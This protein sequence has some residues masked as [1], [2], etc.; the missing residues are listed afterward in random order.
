VIEHV[1][2]IPSEFKRRDLKNSMKEALVQM[3]RYLQ[4]KLPLGSQLLKDLSC[5]APHNI[6]DE[7]SV[8]AIG[9]LAALVPH[10]VSDREVS[11]VKDEW[12]LLRVALMGQ[13]CS[14]DHK[15]SKKKES[16]SIR[17]DHFWSKTL[18]GAGG[19][20]LHLEKVVK[21]LMCLQNGNASVER[22]LSDN[23]NTITAERTNLDLQTLKGLRLSKDYARWQGGAHKIDTFS[24]D[25]I[26]A[27][28]NA[29]QCYLERKKEEEK[30]KSLLLEEQSRKEKDAAAAKE[31]FDKIDKSRKNIDQREEQLEKEE[32][33][34]NE[35]YKLAERLLEDASRNL[36]K[37]I[38]E[39]DMVGIKIANEM[40]ENARNKLSRV[41]EK[42]DDHKKQRTILK[43]KRKLAMDTF[44][45]KAAKNSKR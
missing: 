1:K 4:K 3:T 15:E 16:C 44:L 37:A 41:T 10:V 25:M 11:L 30:E 9:R 22:S 14:D 39:G 23:K 36:T 7:M 5:L 42:R 35:D 40:V 8:N 20:F 12:K 38:E 26:L 21:S 24:K 45:V 28:R 13:D 31:A 33:A 43:K 29:H 18:S 19:K 34:A 6:K 17:L 32:E 27:A 2:S